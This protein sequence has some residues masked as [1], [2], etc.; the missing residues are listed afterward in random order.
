[1]LQ[2]LISQSIDQADKLNRQTAIISHNDFSF[3]SNN[4]VPLLTIVTL[5]LHI[6]MSMIFQLDAV[7]SMV[8]ACERALKLVSDQLAIK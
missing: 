4:L 8:S 3:Q 2:F 5:C 7:Q 6:P 1:M